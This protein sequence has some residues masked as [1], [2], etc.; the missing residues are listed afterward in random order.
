MQ[1]QSGN[2]P[3]ASDRRAFGH[4]RGKAFRDACELGLPQLAYHFAP[5]FALSYPT[6]SSNTTV[7]RCKLPNH[8]GSRWNPAAHGLNLLNRGC[9]AYRCHPYCCSETAGARRD[10][11]AFARR[12]QQRLNVHAW[13]RRS[14]PFVLLAFVNA[15]KPRQTGT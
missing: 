10:A 12:T 15:A 5:R 6:R 2:R 7:W 8:R 11:R 9:A 13:N 14:Q 4:A 1:R 3:L